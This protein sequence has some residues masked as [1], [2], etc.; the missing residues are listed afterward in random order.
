MKDSVQTSGKR[1]HAIAR[2]TLKPGKGIVRI[3]SQKLEFYN[4]PL[5]RAKIFEALQLAG[6]AAKKVNID[7]NV[8]GGGWQAQAEASRLA[9]AKSLVEFT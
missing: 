8:F 7:V 3:N 4:P 6:D 5:A 1:K 2:A 9:I